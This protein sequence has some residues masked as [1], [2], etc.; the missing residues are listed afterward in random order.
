MSDLKPECLDFDQHAKYSPYKKRPLT[1][2]PIEKNLVIRPMTS[3]TL[4]RN[5]HYRNKSKDLQLLNKIKPRKIKIDKERLYEENLALKQSSNHLIEELI[6][7]KTRYL[8]LEKEIKRKEEDG[9]ISF[10]G[11]GFLINTLKQSVKDLKGEVSRKNSE[12]EKLRRS[13][14]ITKLGEYEVQMNAF[15]DECVR[16]KHKLEEVL[17]RNPN[18]NIKPGLNSEEEYVLKN[19]KNEREEFNKKLKEVT[20]ENLELRSRIAEM[21]KEQ[22]E[23]FEKKEEIERIKRESKGNKQKKSEEQFREILEHNK[24][25]EQT[26]KKLEQE[27]EIMAKENEKLEKNKKKTLKGMKSEYKE[28]IK[29]AQQENEIKNK[30]WE[31]IVENLKQELEEKEKS[32]FKALE[33]LQQDSKMKRSNS[34]LLGKKMKIENKEKKITENPDLVQNILN[35]FDKKSKEYEHLIEIKTQESEELN[36]KFKISESQTLELSSMLDQKTREIQELAAILQQKTQLVNE[37]NIE[38]DNKTKE[39]LENKRVLI[40]YPPRLFRVFNEV[41]LRENIELGPLLKSFECEDLI[42]A[43]ELFVKL[44][45]KHSKTKKSMI[46]E[47]SGMLRI[48][49]H[50][51]SLCRISEIFSIF[52]FD[53]LEC[54]SDSD[55]ASIEKLKSFDSTIQS[56]PLEIME[57]K[58]TTQQSLIIKVESNKKIIYD[59]KEEFPEIQLKKN[60]STKKLENCEFEESLNEAKG[61]FLNKSFKENSEKAQSGFFRKSLNDFSE[62]LKSGD[63]DNQKSEYSEKGNKKLLEKAHSEYSDTKKA[64]S[65]YSGSEKEPEKISDSN[66]VPNLLPSSINQFEQPKPS[67]FSEIKTTANLTLSSIA[68]QLFRHLAFRLQLNSIPKTNLIHQ[69]FPSLTETEQISEADL[70]QRLQSNQF[71]FSYNESKCIASYLFTQPSLQ[72][73]ELQLKLSELT[74]D[75]EEYSKDQKFLFEKQLKKVFSKNFGKILENCRKIDKNNKHVVA[76]KEFSEILQRLGIEIQEKVFDYFLLV[77]YQHENKLDEVP[78][79]AMLQRW[80]EIKE[81]SKGQTSDETQEIARHYLA[82]IAKVLIQ[83]KKKAKDFFETNGKGMILP[84]DFLLGLEKVGLGNIDVEFKVAL[85]DAL[86]YEG[87]DEHMISLSELEGILEYYGVGTY[88]EKEEVHNLNSSK[89]SELDS[90]YFEDVDESFNKSLRLE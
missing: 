67:K 90:V 77:C 1:S 58:P 75:W 12:I 45:E 73:I 23:I 40:K 63:S 87:A 28:L 65:E 62:K 78:Y 24:S 3:K 41:I 59:S 69:L 39:L 38:I 29:I 33:K 74:E 2:K 8:H 15:G 30:E 20:R 37:L 13:L 19:L 81:D 35:E 88:E 42:S 49:S 17:A 86:H 4:K 66:F 47:I 52:S 82:V 57:L 54:I 11:S 18:A 48:N 70:E 51:L 32:R 80:T 46:S 10:S 27:I 9:Q 16:L 36:K 60:S 79:L 64:R 56:K 83:N 53:N 50:F 7:V 55:S 76:A 34:E 31:K 21:E 85:L 84:K 22:G 44:R 26:V 89:I 61:D 25:L 72:I 14:K 43:E 71:N 5:F 6:K 68:K